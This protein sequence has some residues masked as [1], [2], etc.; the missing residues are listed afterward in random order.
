VGR[1]ALLTGAALL[2]LAA[3]GYAATPPSGGG[4]A[5]NA[6][7]GKITGGGS[8]L[9]DYLQQNVW[10]PDYAQDVCGPVANS[11]SAMDNSA[12][13]MVA[14]NPPESVNLGLTGS[15]FGILDAECHVYA[16]AA[17]D[18][19]YD[20]AQ[21]TEL[22]AGGEAWTDTA[23]DDCFGLQQETRPLPLPFTPP[24]TVFPA[25]NDNVSP[26]QVMSFPVAGE[27]VVVA[28]NFTTGPPANTQLPGCPTKSLNLTGP[29]LSLLFGGD[30]LNWDDPRLRSYGSGQN[31]GLATCNE[32]VTRVV[33]DGDSGTTAILKDYLIHAD[34]DRYDAQSCPA[35]NG[36]AL[37]A[38][39]SW[40][41]YATNP[42]TRWP[43]GYVIDEE[44]DTPFIPNT[45]AGQFFLVATN[46]EDGNC[47]PIEAPILDEVQDPSE[48]SGDATEFLV[49]QNTPGAVGYVDLAD[50]ANRGENEYDVPISSINVLN[51]AGT[52]FQ[53]ASSGPGANCSFVGATLPGAGLTAV[54]GL[55]AADTWASD[56][57]TVNGTV[58]H[59]NVTDMGTAYPICGF[60]WQLVCAGLDVPFSTTPGAGGAISWLTNDQRRTLYS[61]VTYELSSVGQSRLSSHHY[62]ALPVSWMSSLLGG[63]QVFF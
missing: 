54:V 1:A 16:F 35:P 9:E 10:G 41:Y 56:N 7:D 4:V 61:Y 46:G 44:P 27:S 2:A 63:F 45:E 22:Q 34:P 60:T 33:A 39:E 24:G 47:S 25:G 31:S 49:L 53:S 38:P 20:S 8:T 29:Q 58:D 43:G 3:N 51:G 62:Q 12:N 59:A 50:Y 42:N 32:P 28:A 23:P 13:T 14:Y 52:S 55:N 15:G 11:G 26:S 17:S 37:G 21:Y 57:A 48:L 5:C 30:I 6:V 36:D 18:V 40:A 19:P